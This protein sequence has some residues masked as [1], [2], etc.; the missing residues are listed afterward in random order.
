[1][2][3]VAEQR[4]TLLNQIIA[5]RASVKTDTEQK[6][7][8]LYHLLQKPSLLQGQSRTY[9]PSDD[10]GF[11]YPAETS[12]VQFKVE[13]A[14]RD[15]SAIMT[16]LFDV[17]AQLDWSNQHARAD[18]VLLG[19]ETPVTV[20]R[21]VPVSY[22]LFL[23]K[24]LIHLETVIRKLPTL[25]ATEEWEFD[26]NQDVY[27]TKP[28]STVKTKKVL[29]NHVKADATE[30][31]PAQVETYTEDL[32]I[33]TWNTVKFSGALP[34]TKVNAMLMRVAAL[35][36]AVK[37]AREQANLADIVKVNPGRAIL[38]YVFAVG[39]PE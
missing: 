12:N 35:S 31:H 16:D 23:D 15:I 37:F 4:T 2:T 25:D 13:W 3:A 11:R 27:R 10:D 32:P 9:T 18:V 33:G 39:A 28:V 19:G 36:R 17:T 1:M 29:R 38:D 30:R 7:T 6:L 8:K 5:V 22:L 20:L 24:Q 14:L 21:D 26:A 34:A